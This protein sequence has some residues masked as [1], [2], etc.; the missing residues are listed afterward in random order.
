MCYRMWLGSLKWSSCPRQAGWGGS[1]RDPLL[2]ACAAAG[3]E[4]AVPT[5]PVMILRAR[6]TLHAVTQ[7]ARFAWLQLQ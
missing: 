3:T 1:R 2:V 7:A 6:V 5:C 4:G